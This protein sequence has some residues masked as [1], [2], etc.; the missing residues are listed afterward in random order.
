MSNNNATWDS[1]KLN[2]LIYE[3][4]FCFAINKPVGISVIGEQLGT[5]IVSI[6]AAAGETIFPVHRIDKVTS[7]VVL[8]AKDLPSHGNLT[9]QFAK[10]TVIKRYLAL[11][12]PGGLPTEGTIDLALSIGRKNRVRIA[13]DRDDI[14]R[15]ENTWSTHG[16]NLEFN[17]KKV[18]PSVT[19]FKTI[20][21]T[22]K[23]ALI[24][25][26]PQTGRRH[27]IRTHLAWIGH[28][29]LG[30][31]LYPRHDKGPYSVKRTSLHSWMLE[32]ESASL[33]GESIQIV[34]PPN[35]EIWSAIMATNP[36]ISE[37]NINNV[38]LN[39]SNVSYS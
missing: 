30:D 36:E 11:V 23:Y 22:E 17:N 18:Y 3:D 33:S 5:N 9:R 25:A 24:M 19:K 6:A 32:F 4:K 12:H 2:Y 15:S 28:P 37:E 27:Q 10:R 26:T 38:I 8:F 31:P 39:L 13:A 35:P 20:L 29:I 21:D 16:N 1:F 14:V 7:G 34:A